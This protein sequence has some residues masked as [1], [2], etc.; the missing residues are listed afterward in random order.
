MEGPIFALPGQPPRHRRKRDADDVTA[1]DMRNLQAQLIQA[2]SAR[3]LLEVSAADLGALLEEERRQSYALSLERDA[4]QFQ[5]GQQRGELD[6]TRLLLMEEQ[7]RV[8][9]LQQDLGA[10]RG[11]VDQLQVALLEE[12]MRTGALQQELGEAKQG[13]QV[14]LSSVRAELEAQ[15]CLGQEAVTR[16]AQEQENNRLNQVAIEHLEGAAQQSASALTEAAPLLLRL[17]NALA[18]MADHHCDAENPQAYSEWRKLVNEAQ[19][20]QLT[21]PRLWSGACDVL[22][23]LVPSLI[24]LYQVACATNEKLR[25]EYDKV[26]SH[27]QQLE[28]EMAQAEQVFNKQVE[29][30][31]Q[32]LARLDQ[33]VAIDSVVVD[34]AK[35]YEQLIAV[36]EKKR[37]LEEHIKGLER[38]V[39]SL[40][41]LVARLREDKA[42]L[43][44]RV[45]ALQEA[46][47]PPRSLVLVREL[48]SM[49][50]EEAASLRE[51]LG[52]VDSQHCTLCVLCLGRAQEAERQLEMTRAAMKEEQRRLVRLAEDQ[53][54]MYEA[55]RRTLE[56]DS[57]EA[58]RAAQR[59]QAKVYRQLSEAETKLKALDGA[60]T[61]A[62][63]EAETRAKEQKVME[64]RRLAAKNAR[65]DELQLA[66]QQAAVAVPALDVLTT[67]LQRHYASHAQVQGFQSA[68]EDCR[69]CEQLRAAPLVAAPAYQRLASCTAQLARV[70]G[71]MA[72]DPK[73]HHQVGADRLNILRRFK[74]NVDAAA[75]LIYRHVTDNYQLSEEVR[76]S[77]ANLMQAWQYAERSIQLTTTAA[78]E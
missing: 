7:V 32:M 60:M 34:G 61:K 56:N 27:A 13:H 40:K 9:G 21:N 43:E 66:A 31:R 30:N 55:R 25:I 33:R 63:E 49:V 6:G 16:L 42:A 77:V 10:L 37:D 67:L 46:V 26:A 52:L 19:T 48:R 8:Y 41:P 57:A 29:A 65:I 39:G 71:D 70:M 3:H 23:L 17:L 78:K 28:R 72:V 35:V 50:D 20:A 14:E 74:A 47:P 12:Q 69:R 75:P 36:S 62:K 51:R 2:N 64:E 54:E 45:R 1:D 68:L 4:L 44:S 59:E 24:Q 22:E 53:K 18:K 76:T 73:Q 58:G 38:L 15:R 5:L 11:Q